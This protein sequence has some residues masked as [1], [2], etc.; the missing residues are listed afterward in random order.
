[1]NDVDWT[2]ALFASK[3]SLYVEI[4]DMYI[5]CSYMCQKF[6]QHDRKF[7]RVHSAQNEW[8]MYAQS[9]L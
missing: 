3:V 9:A 7:V 6:R 5:M 2:V 1:M 4:S 8:N